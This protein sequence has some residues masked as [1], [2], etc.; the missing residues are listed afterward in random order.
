MFQNLAQQF[1]KT[2]QRT[3]KSPLPVS[4]VVSS[5]E[6]RWEVYDGLIKYQNTPISI[7]RKG[8]FLMVLASSR[9]CF[10]FHFT[11]AERIKSSGTKQKNPF[12]FRRN[13]EVRPD[14]LL[15]RFTLLRPPDKLNENHFRQQIIFLNKKK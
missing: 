7:E 4:A 9:L 13:D 12:R 8:N 14:A 2:S 6:V 3:R 5:D 1:I 11:F 15:R 10:R